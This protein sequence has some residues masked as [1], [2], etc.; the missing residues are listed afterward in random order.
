MK[1]CF[2][3]DL[4]PDYIEGLTGEEVRREMKEHLENCGDCRAVYRQMMADIPQEVFS[5]DTDIDFL[6]KLR[7]TIRKRYAYVVFLTCI[8]LI[9][10]FVLLKN[11]YLPVPYDPDRMS[12]EFYQAVPVTDSYGITRWKEQRSPEPERASDAASVDL[13]RLVLTGPIQ[14]D[15]AV[16]IGRTVERD[17][18]K[19]RVV[20]YCYT[21]A[22][23]S[24]LFAGSRPLVDKMTMS[25]HIY[26]NRLEQ[27]EYKPLMTEIYYLPV[28][29]MD[30][31][32]RLSDQEF[33]AKKEDAVLVWSGVN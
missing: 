8:V 30:S 17:G 9:C 19:V 16:S 4:L 21:R 32:E 24:S 5:D 10:C 25:G 27:A 33:E 2:V 7:T 12:T 20:Y 22:L 11:C 15:D 26:G 6:K 29:N 13:V 23:W 1:C 3:K 18:E 14:I 31:L 28:R